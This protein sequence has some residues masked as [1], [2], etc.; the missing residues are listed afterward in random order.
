MKALRR[1]SVNTAP[2]ATS[3][4]SDREQ[5]SLLDRT[6]EEA[7]CS[8]R[9]SCK[10]PSVQQFSYKIHACGPRVAG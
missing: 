9:R 1:R 7:F 5:R 8:T 6:H 3:P 10:S 4:I 2:N